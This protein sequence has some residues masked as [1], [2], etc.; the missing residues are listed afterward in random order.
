MWRSKRFRRAC[1]RMGIKYSRTRVRRPQTNGKAERFIKTALREWAY[2]R[3]CRDYCERAK[4]LM[5]WLHRYNWHRPHASLNYK[6][7]GCRRNGAGSTSSRV[8]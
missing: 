5:P 7:P 4:E 8:F 3:I 2:V 1:E 6:A